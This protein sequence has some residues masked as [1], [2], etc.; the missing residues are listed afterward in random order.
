MMLWL[1]LQAVAGIG[2][3]VCAG[4]AQ[5]ALGPDAQTHADEADAGHRHPASTLVDRGAPDQG[6]D[7]SGDQQPADPDAAV[8]SDCAMACA[9]FAPLARL[10]VSPIFPCAGLV[11]QADESFASA[12]VHQALE[13]PITAA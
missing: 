13:P 5:V 2:A 4:A 1:P 3:P 8:C 7:H 6:V 9:A 12:S 10:T 11:D